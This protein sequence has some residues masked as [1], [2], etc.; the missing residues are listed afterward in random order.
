MDEV[1]SIDMDD[2]DYLKGSHSRLRM[3]ATLTRA[4]M[5]RLALMSSE[6]RAA[7]AL[8]RHYPGGTLAFVAAMNEKAIA[9]GMTRTHYDDSTGLSPRNVST[10]N[11]LAKL[12]R[13][14]ADYPLIREYS[15]TP[16]HY[17]EVQATGQTLG[18]NNSNALVKNGAW[19]IQLQKT[20]YIREA[21]RCVVMLATIASKPMVIVL[22]D[23]H[24]QVH[25]RGRRPA[26]QALARDRRVDARDRVQGRDEAE[27]AE[28]G[29]QQ[30]HP[31]QVRGDQSLSAARAAAGVSAVDCSY[32]S[33]ACAR[34]FAVISAPPSILASSST[35]AFAS[36]CARSLTHVL[37]AARLGHAQVRVGERGHLRQVRDAQHLAPRRR[38]PAEAADRR[39]DRAADARV[40]FVEHERGHGAGFARHHR[41]A[42]AMRDSSPP[43]ATRASGAGRLLG[44]AR[45]AELDA[46]EPVAR[47]RASGSSA[48]SKRP[49]AIASVCIVS[50][51]RCASSLAWNRRFVD[52]SLA[53]RAI[54]RFGLAP[55]AWRAPRASA[56][57]ASDAR[58][59]SVSASSA[60]KRLRPHAMLARDVVDRGQP[61]LDALQ[62]RRIEVEP[63][64]VI[65]QRA[66]GFVEL[67]GR[68]LEQ[69]R[70][71]RRARDRARRAARSRCTRCASARGDRVVGLAQRRDAVARERDQLGGMRE[72]RLRRGQ[73]APLVLGDG[74]RRELALALLEELALGRGRFRRA[75][76]RVA[77]ARRRRA[78]RASVAPLRC[79]SVV[80]PPNASTTAR[81]DFRLLERLVRVLAVD[82]DEHLAQR[83]QLRERG[84]RCR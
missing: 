13:A 73:V 68:R 42:S 30:A 55:R 18:F 72:A 74:E 69:R 7:S 44:M 11:D 33:F 1:L 58:R 25:A 79:V 39:R 5:L 60:G 37:V 56:E 62:L 38:A 9:L 29:A 75:G 83:L 81:C 77:G 6:N 46:V 84:R 43:D 16:S 78:T 24:R 12:V 82:R 31:G 15:T 65:A 52:R 27:G 51:T 48:T 21:G 41:N 19:D 23:S 54:L 45:D 59:A 35:R 40:D 47:R 2:F 70:R 67:D 8:A 20:G 3:G 71:L 66:R 64:L 76:R 14:A 36:S 34:V 10:A 28:V 22:L 63:A 50:V 61:V 4:E 57:S 53:A 49:P 26:R 17:V 80:K 32:S